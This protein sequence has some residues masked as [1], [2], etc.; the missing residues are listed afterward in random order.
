MLAASGGG[1]D[2]KRFT[3]AAAALRSPAGAPLAARVGI[4]T[5]LIVVGDL[6][7]AGGS[8]E[9]TVVGDT[10][11]LADR[12]QALARPGAVL[13]RETTRRLLGELFELEYVPAAT[14][15][16]FAGPVAAFRI[17]GERA[18]ESRFE[19]L[20]PAGIMPLVG[21]EHELGFLLDR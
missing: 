2:P 21:R 17:L 14:I 13:I 4:A 7:G 11:N 20:H 8:Q 16:G 1:C 9:E 10:P 15:K 12:L 5:G 19:A 18:I 3:Q 6:V